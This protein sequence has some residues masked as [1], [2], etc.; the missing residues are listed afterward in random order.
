MRMGEP[1]QLAASV[2]ANSEVDGASPSG[3]R[4]STPLPGL[5]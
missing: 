1:R 3:Q 2:V 5:S 4:E